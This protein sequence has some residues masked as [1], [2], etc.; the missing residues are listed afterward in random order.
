MDWHL[1]DTV[2]WTSPHSKPAYTSPGFRIAAS[3]NA[4]QGMIEPN[5]ECKPRPDSLMAWIR[6]NNV[7][8]ILGISVPG[9]RQPLSLQDTIPFPDSV[10]RLDSRIVPHEAT[11]T[12][13]TLS[14]VIIMS[15]NPDRFEDYSH[16]ADVPVDGII[17]RMKGALIFVSEFRRNFDTVT[18]QASEGLVNP[19]RAALLIRSQAS[20]SV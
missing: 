7:G 11:V 2:G 6:W 17:F 10:C 9:E 16:G 12:V 8:T 4:V 3:A 5:A 20:R 1:P 15:P 19:N 14:E 13:P 18:A